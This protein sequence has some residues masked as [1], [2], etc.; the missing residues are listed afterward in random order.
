MS[1][2]KNLILGI[3][4]LL[5]APL[6]KRVSIFEKISN[7]DFNFLTLD[8]LCYFYI[9]SNIKLERLLKIRSRKSRLAEQSNTPW[10]PS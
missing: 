1:P 4:N 7:D 3:E 9:G 6:F 5:V 8:F 10:A 2:M